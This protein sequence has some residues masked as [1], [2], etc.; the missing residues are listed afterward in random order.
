M[1]LV[2]RTF[3]SHRTWLAVPL[4]AV[5]FGFVSSQPAAAK[6][7]EWA[8]CSGAPG[9]APAEAI[10]GCTSLLN[11][12]LVNQATN[13]QG[14]SFVL[15]LRGP[16]YYL[17][18]KFDQAITDFDAA[19]Q[20]DPE[21][22]QPMH[23]RGLVY[24]AEGDLD[25]AIS[26]FSRVISREPAFEPAYFRRGLAWY[27][28]ND[29]EHAI[30]DFD[31]AVSRDPTD[32]LSFHYRGLSH[33]KKGETELAIADFNAALKL[34]PKDA[35][36]YYNRGNAF[37]A[38]KDTAHAM[39]DYDQAIGLDGHDVRFLKA[40]GN[41]KREGGDLDGAPADLDAAL[42]IKPGDQK[43]LLSRSSVYAAKGDRTRA[44]A[45]YAA[46]VTAMLRQAM[47]YPDQAQEKRE[48]GD[49]KVTFA[50]DR[51]GKVTSSAITGSS[52]HQLLDREALA[53][54]QR[55]QPFPSPGLIGKD[56][57]DFATTITFKLF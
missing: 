11:T 3:P 48:Q 19:I 21:R 33:S 38:A 20:L 53:M 16:Q 45:D 1:P 5:L 10:D 57:E 37:L 25:R 17:A 2:S 42:Q 47:L 32:E 4:A 46:V 18:Q 35:L 7:L 24:A 23:Y 41:L 51:D 31:S 13:P 56:A 43:A 50:I 15:A 55:A 29:F 26:D 22:A 39:A 40:R 14:R 27:T 36:A 9:V 8:R 44:E 49:V 30:A 6:S 34:N 28:K 54:I 52:N 12:P